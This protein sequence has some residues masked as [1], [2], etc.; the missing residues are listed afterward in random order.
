LFS[1][2]VEETG[3][4]I[5]VSGSSLSFQADAVFGDLKPGD[6]VA[7]NGVCLTVTAISGKSFRVDVMPET[8]KRSTLGALKTGDLVNLERALTLSGRLGGHLVEGHIDATGVV[9]RIVMEGDAELMTVTAPPG[10]M[11]YVVEKGFMAVDGL[12]LTV[13]GHT[14]DNFTVSLVA[15][16]R[17]HTTMGRKRVGDR[18]NLEVDIIAKYVENFVSR[19]ESK[20]TEGFLAEH[21]FTS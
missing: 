7:V 9:A 14:S 16:S 15:F 3:A 21:G 8:L 2:I 13:A 5:A 19:R 10:V 18:V 20:V 4:L 6:S 1:G 11:R 17:S 12:S